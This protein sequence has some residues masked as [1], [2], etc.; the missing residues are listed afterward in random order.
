[1]LQSK[2]SIKSW[3]FLL[4]ILVSFIMVSC[5][6]GK[7]WPIVEEEYAIGWLLHNI[8][9]STDTMLDYSIDD[10]MQVNYTRNYPAGKSMR[11]DNLVWWIPPTHL[12]GGGIAGATWTKF[13]VGSKRSAYLL[14]VNP[15][16]QNYR[17]NWSFSHYMQI[18]YAVGENKDAQFGLDVAHS[19]RHDNYNV[20]NAITPVPGDFMDIYFGTAPFIPTHLKV[21]ENN[22]RLADHL[23]SGYNGNSYLTRY[24]YTTTVSS[25]RG[26]TYVVIDAPSYSLYI[27]GT[28][29]ENRNIT[30]N[31]GRWEYRKLNIPLIKGGDYIVDITIPSN[32]PVFN[33]TRIVSYFSNPSDDIQPPWIEKLEVA[34][35]Y[36]PFEV[37]PVKI[38]VQDDV[39]VSSVSAYYFD[40]H[41]NDITLDLIGSAYS[42]FIPSYSRIKTDLMIVV[43]DTSDNKVEYFIEP[44]SLPSENVSLVWELNKDTF[45][46]GDTLIIKGG[47]FLMNE[48]NEPEPLDNLLL[49]FYVNGEKILLQRTVISK[50]VDYQFLF[51]YFI[52]FNFSDNLNITI[53]FEGSGIY[54]GFS[55]SISVDVLRDDYD[56][57]LM[58]L[59]VPRVYVGESSDLHVNVG[60]TGKFYQENVNVSFFVSDAVYNRIPQ[61]IESQLVNLQPGEIKDLVFPLTP[62]SRSNYVF[63]YVNG[64]SLESNIENNKLTKY[65]YSNARVDFYSYINRDII[66]FVINKSGQVL[67]SVRNIGESNSSGNVTFYH[68]NSSC[69]YSYR[70]R[71]GFNLISKQEFGVLSANKKRDINFTWKPPREG[72][73]VLKTVVNVTGDVVSDNDISYTNAFVRKDL[74]DMDVSTYSIPGNIFADVPNNFLVYLRNRGTKT[75]NNVSFDFYYAFNCSHAFICNYT[76]INHFDVGSLDPSFHDYYVLN[77][78]WVPPGNGSYMIKFSVN[79]T[80]DPYYGN[81]RRYRAVIVNSSEDFSGFLPPVVDD[82]PGDDPVSSSGGS[83]GGGGGSGGGG[84]VGVEEEQCISNWNCFSWSGCDG[85]VQKRTCKNYGDCEGIKPAIERSCVVSTAEGKGGIGI[86]LLAPEL[87]AGQITQSSESIIIP[88]NVENKNDIELRHMY[89]E[90]DFNRGESTKFVDII[91]RIEIPEQGGRYTHRLINK[92]NLKKEKYEIKIKL[93]YKGKLIEENKQEIEVI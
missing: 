25:E 1:M 51:D 65:V 75:A 76:L 71:C 9:D 29:E 5:N 44:V 36:D 88:I 84:S 62:Q 69:Q 54:E 4:L 10:L 32:Y 12:Y 81:N 57:L 28:L 93:Y 3:M 87:E 19:E 40:D 83:G 68:G 90:I 47:A 11:F 27:N 41:W 45:F 92:D 82:D 64:S 79:C 60:N 48:G 89:V 8:N 2:K 18:N 42:G 91:D 61:L 74:P 56:L 31:A 43:K 26:T 53:S 55:K 33:N 78:T 52:P 20:F 37:L 24:T 67:V 63:I 38:F 22:I 59:D 34:P 30:N 6:D 58:D 66:H 7:L 23:L 50:Y 39:A 46:P 16:T 72:F 70:N 13:P 80:D 86:E 14:G 77:S 21:S 35:S 85:G 73:N 15:I 49:N 17:M